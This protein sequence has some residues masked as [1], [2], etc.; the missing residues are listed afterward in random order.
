[1]KSQQ[2]IDQ[3]K[4]I[5]NGDPW[6]GNSVFTIFKQA[7]DSIIHKKLPQIH[8]IAEIVLHLVAWNE[9]AISRLKGNTASAPARGDWPGASNYTWGELIGMFKQSYKDLHNTILEITEEQ[10]LSPTRDERQPALGTGVTYEEL[11][12]GLMQHFVY[13]SGQV[14]LLVKQLK[15]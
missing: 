10:W 9:E 12:H 1:M 14:A 6:H 5:T 3:L 2:L 11:V 7:D 8:T 4:Q 15:S 13:H